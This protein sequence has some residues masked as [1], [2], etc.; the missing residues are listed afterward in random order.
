MN[1]NLLWL[2]LIPILLLGIVELY[3]H[4]FAGIESKDVWKGMPRAG[5]INLLLI[6]ILFYCFFSLSDVYAR[7]ISLIAV[8]LLSAPLTVK[9][10]KYMKNHHNVFPIWLTSQSITNVVLGGLCIW[11]IYVSV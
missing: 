6:F 5:S 3:I 10:Y 7:A 9:Q 8:V 11:V 4:K 2:F 1:T